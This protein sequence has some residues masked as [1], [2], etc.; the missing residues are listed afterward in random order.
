MTG[1]SC[2]SIL[3]CF[4]SLKIWVN[5]FLRK[6]FRG[7]GLSLLM[8]KHHCKVLRRVLF[9][10]SLRYSAYARLA[11]HQIKN[12]NQRIYVDRSGFHLAYK[13]CPSQLFL[14]HNYRRILVMVFQ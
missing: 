13:H 10:W 9:P 12:L 8:E 14:W 4:D 7:H 3:F 11:Y 2:S 1:D 6:E 5:E